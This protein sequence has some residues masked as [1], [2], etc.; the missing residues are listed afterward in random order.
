MS[1]RRTNAGR[2]DGCQ[3]S[4]DSYVHA[5]GGI[6]ALVAQH[7]VQY[8]Y[9]DD[10]APDSQQTGQYATDDAGSQQQQDKRQELG[11]VFSIDELPVV[12]ADTAKIYRQV[13]RVVSY[14]GTRGSGRA[15]VPMNVVLD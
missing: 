6:D 12:S 3:R 10:A 14:A 8:G 4:A 5:N 2:D 13:T 1:Q 7:P 11:H 15:Q 9:Q